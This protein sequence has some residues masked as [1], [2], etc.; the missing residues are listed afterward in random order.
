MDDTAFR[1]YTD[2][3]SE[4]GIPNMQSVLLARYLQNHVQKTQPRP[5]MSGRQ[6]QGDYINTPAFYPSKPPPFQLFG[7]LPQYI[8][9]SS[10]D[11]A[12]GGFSNPFVTPRCS[13]GSAIQAQQRAIAATVKTPLVHNLMNKGGLRESL[14]KIRHKK[15]FSA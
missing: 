8:P 13:Q 15:N 11:E 12:H 9:I 1:G 4:I 10:P 2:A 7:N 3:I 6:R 14:Q 5:L